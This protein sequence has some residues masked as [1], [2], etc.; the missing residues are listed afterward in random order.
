MSLRGNE[1]VKH[2]SLTYS[3]VDCTE[4]KT[5]HKKKDP[6]INKA[7]KKVKYIQH[8]LYVSD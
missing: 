5:G 4:C 2:T 6:E 8:K 3:L 7:E 1:H